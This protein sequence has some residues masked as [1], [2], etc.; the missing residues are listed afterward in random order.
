MLSC[1]FPLLA[2]DVIASAQALLREL[3][4]KLQEVHRRHLDRGGALSAR[5]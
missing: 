2:Q 5:A 4:P 1:G 3:H